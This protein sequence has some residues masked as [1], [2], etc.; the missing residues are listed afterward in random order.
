M[1]SDSSKILFHGRSE[2][3]VI[4]YNKIVYCKAEG[5]CTMIYLQNNNFMVTKVLKC[6]E[7]SLPKTIFLRIHNSYLIN[8]N[9]LIAS[10]QKNSLILDPDIELPISRRRKCKVLKRIKT[11]F[12]T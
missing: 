8:I 1:Q 5:N 9:Y 7:F 12:N 10:T 2:N 4:D 11:F 6:V 3:R